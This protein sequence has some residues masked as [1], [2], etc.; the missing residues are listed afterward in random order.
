MSSIKIY[1][2]ALMYL[3][4]DKLLFQVVTDISQSA[5]I[6]TASGSEKT[7]DCYLYQPPTLNPKCFLH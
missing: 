5:R 7:S 4:K 2:K 1:N 6:L 3:E